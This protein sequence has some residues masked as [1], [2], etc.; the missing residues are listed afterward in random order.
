MQ[1]VKCLWEKRPDKKQAVSLYTKEM[2]KIPDIA[3]KV[4]SFVFALYFLGVV[5]TVPYFNW[6]IAKKEGFASWVLLGQ[7]KATLKGFAWPFWI[8]TST[9]RSSSD[10]YKYFKDSIHYNNEAT[11]IIKKIGPYGE[12]PTKEMDEIIGL[13]QIALAQAKQ[14]DIKMLNSTMPDLG[15]HYQEEFIEGLTLYIEGFESGNAQAALE[16]QILMDRFGEW[17]SDNYKQIR[18]KLY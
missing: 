5:I 9:T 7:V 14:V 10:K 16:G 15:R 18:E 6:Q 8:S 11:R 13:K 1:A 3:E 12:I 2:K 17:Y 4:I